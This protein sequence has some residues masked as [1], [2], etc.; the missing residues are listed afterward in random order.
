MYYYKLDGHKVVPATRDEWRGPIPVHR[1]EL[2]NILIST[3]FLGLDHGYGKA[4]E[5][6]ETMIFGL[7][8]EDEYR[9]QYST[10]NA[11]KQGH[12]RAINYVLSKGWPKK[13]E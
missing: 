7:G 12:A 11:A 3:V 2:E 8:D 13:E 6:F 5:V 1:I 4:P 9:E 10:W